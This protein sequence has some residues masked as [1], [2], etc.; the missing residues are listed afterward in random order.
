MVSFLAEF[1]LSSSLCSRSFLTPANTRSLLI[2]PSLNTRPYSGISSNSSGN[3]R[4][5]RFKT[6]KPRAAAPEHLKIAQL[7]SSALSPDRASPR[8]TLRGDARSTLRACSHFE[9]LRQSHLHRVRSLSTAPA[10]YISSLSTCH[11][12]HSYTSLLSASAVPSTLATATNKPLSA[13]RMAAKPFDKSSDS[14]LSPPPDDYVSAT[15][16]ATTVQPTVHGQT[17]KPIAIRSKRRATQ[18]VISQDAPAEVPVS[19]RLRRAATRKPIIDDETMEG[20]FDVEVSVREI[21]KS[22]TTTDSKTTVKKPTT[23]KKRKAEDD[24][25]HEEQPKPV[26][27]KRAKT[28]STTKSEESIADR[29]TDSNHLIGAHVS[30]GGGKS[31]SSP[32]HLLQRSKANMDWTTVD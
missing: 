32:S 22:K 9:S 1:F 5:N 30:I 21:Q 10:V 31:L 23:S 8:N 17:S 25:N 7:P 19:S 27:K 29:T 12:C 15:E 6:H 20:E 14:S 18:E 28:V 11:L 13:P 26:V 16:I 24:G 2:Y 4:R 3:Q